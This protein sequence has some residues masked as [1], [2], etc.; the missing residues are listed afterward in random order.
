RTYGLEKITERHRHRYE[1]NND[2]RG[3]YQQWGIMASGMSP[4]DSLVEM[5][6]VPSHPYF[7][8]TQAH[9]EFRSRPDRPHPLFTGLV[10]TILA[11]P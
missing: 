5:I 10:R 4:D 7:I 6:E 8:A 9:P 11:K 2:Y 3:K 1:A